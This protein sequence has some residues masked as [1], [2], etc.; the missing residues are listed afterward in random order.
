[1]G[2]QGRIDM[3]SARN[4]LAALLLA[5][6]TTVAAQ[7][8]GPAVAPAPAKAARA[9]GFR[10]GAAF[11]AR[12]RLPAPD[13]A[14]IADMKAANARARNKRVDVGVGRDLPDADAGAPS[15]I[16]TADGH[17]ARWHVTSDGAEALRVALRAAD[18]PQ[19]SELRFAGSGQPALVYGPFS[20]ADVAAAGAA[21]WSPVLEGDTATVEAFVPARSALPAIAV[22]GV[23]HLFVSPSNP[24][25]EAIAKAAGPC[26]VNFICRAATDAALAQAGRSVARMNFITQNGTSSFCSGTLLNPG[27]GSLTP[28]FYSAAHCIATPSSAASLTTHWFYESATCTSNTVGSSEIQ[29]PGGSVLLHANA[30]TDVA[31]FRLNASPPSGAVYAGWDAATVTR[32]TAVTAIHHPDA[33][34]KKVSLGAIAGF[35]SYPT[36]SGSFARVQWNGLATG[37][38]EP[39]SSGSGIFS[40][41]GGSLRFRGGL[42]GGASSC[43][44]STDELWD[45]YSRL[46]LAFPF[47]AQ[48]LSPAG[49]PAL[50]ANT[51][52]NAGFETGA[53]SWAQASSVGANVIVNDAGARS[54]GW[55][56][57]LGDA[58]NVTESVHQTIT[59]PPGPARLQFWYRV[60]S[61]ETTAT[62][63]FDIL[64]VSIN[65]AQS[66][67]TLRTLGTLSNLDASA[68]WVQSPVYDVAEFGGRAVRLQLRAVNDLS[69]PSSFRIDDV[70]LNGA[71]VAPPANHT[72]LWWNASES[73][74]GINV[75]HQGDIAFATLFTYTSAG[76][77]MWLV[78]PSGARQEGAATFM[79]ALYRTTGPAFNA[80]PFT[81]LGPTNIT[82]VGTMT[83]DFNGGAPTLAY[84]F[85]ETY[86]SKSVEKQV[87][88]VSAANCQ[89]TAGSRAG[90]TNYQDLWW[91]P[92]ESG[93]GINLT[94]QGNIIFATLFT[95]AAN[96]Q[97]MWLVLPA[98]A[99]QG[100]G[101]FMGEL[102]RTTGPAFNAQPW[103]GIGFSVVGT[104]RLRFQSGD[105][106][107]LEY[108]V[109]GANVTK[110]ITRQ[111]FGSP[112]PI[113]S[114]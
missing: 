7:S 110:A 23:S 26:E 10:A 105:T 67:T 5:A 28:Y 70:T 35:D 95:Y 4:A 97:G 11:A 12:I 78:M 3:T 107:T 92:A 113:C 2:T 9:D 101:S 30:E 59:I 63:R 100:D 1:M 77:P 69:A 15:W 54:G 99:R 82:E 18:L 64:T 74:W 56:A 38:T 72:A 58:D 21:Y 19:G 44:A 79:G 17:V 108:S 47:I 71:P 85:N 88:G 39:G 20:A 98:G 90:A 68:G 91:N 48:H 31:F 75:T 66:G 13:P 45:V 25:A 102:Y 29:V 27:D 112:A 114:G 106:G 51:V 36:A 93:W 80:V 55:Y 57:W 24:R 40:D 104:M 86:V 33:D 94:H 16:G 84:T 41:A 52:A 81:P 87:Y 6:T 14:A 22:G 34:I 49:A 32:G 43:T 37:V 76:A 109:D 8:N 42:L 89:G 111:V 50:G 73:G 62:R 96:G 83:L 46:D 53:A 60:S 61:T 65:D 103:P